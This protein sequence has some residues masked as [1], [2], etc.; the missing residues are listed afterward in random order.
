MKCQ[1]RYRFSRL[2]YFRT[3]QNSWTFQYY[4]TA[5]IM[6]YEVYLLNILVKCF[7]LKIHNCISALAFN[8]KHNSYHYIRI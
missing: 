5:S 6:I 2:R 4:A 8:M 3:S 1:H 7:N